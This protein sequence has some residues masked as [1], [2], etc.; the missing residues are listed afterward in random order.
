MVV[1]SS[2]N[3]FVSSTGLNVFTRERYILIGL[4]CLCKQ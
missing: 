3:Q 2:D 1:D 4:V